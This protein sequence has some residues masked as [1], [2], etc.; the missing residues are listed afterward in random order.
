MRLK[1]IPYQLLRAG[2]NWRPTRRLCRPLLAPGFFTPRHPHFG[3]LPAD[4]GNANGELRIVGFPKSGNVWITSLI[5]T[6]L[7]VPVTP[8]PH[9]LRVTHTHHALRASDLFDKQLLRGAVLMRDLRDILVSLYHFSKTPHFENFLGPHFEFNSVEQMYTQF[10]VP[11]YA[12]RIQMLESLPVPYVQFGWPVIRYEDMWDDPKREMRRVF[13]AWGIE[14]S[15]DK[16][17]QAVEKNSLEAM[18][19]GSG[20]TTD[21]VQNTHFRRGGHGGY[22][23]ELPDH[24]L[25][26]IEKRFGDYLSRWGYPLNQT[27]Q[28]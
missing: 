25:A 16:I 8:S 15:D 9:G 20:K 2:L 5:A 23:S 28:D 17:E 22:R 24:I 27:T 21:E 1:E 13:M 10:F 6:C 4:L 19:K 12:N 14:V 3:N 26:D 7:D 18:R 11:Y